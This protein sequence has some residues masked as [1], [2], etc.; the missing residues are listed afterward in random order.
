MTKVEQD[1]LD[2]GNMTKIKQELLDS[3]EKKKRTFSEV[4]S[5]TPE[6]LSLERD[7]DRRGTGV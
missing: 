2:A 3:L 6:M 7:E 4:L 1:L 5:P